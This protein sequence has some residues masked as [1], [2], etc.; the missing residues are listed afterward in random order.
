M[1]ARKNHPPTLA[2]LRQELSAQWEAKLAEAAPSTPAFYPAVQ[3]VFHDHNG[4][5][6]TRVAEAAAAAGEYL[7][8][9]PDILRLT[10]VSL[11]HGDTAYTFTTRPPAGD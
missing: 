8:V 7:S 1:I 2:D 9:D 3:V 11:V 6:A 10:D 4:T 5:H